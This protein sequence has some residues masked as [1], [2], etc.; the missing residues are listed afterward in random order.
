MPESPYLHQAPSVISLSQLEGPPLASPQQAYHG[1]SETQIARSTSTTLDTFHS[2]PDTM[3]SST[4]HT[5]EGSGA[6]E[7]SF[8]WEHLP[9][10]GIVPAAPDAGHPVV[11]VPSPTHSGRRVSRV[12]RILAFFGY[13][14]DNK[15]RKELVSVIWTLSIDLSQMVAIIVLLAYSTHHRSPV[16]PDLNEWEACGKPLGV[17]NALWIGRLAL[18][19]GLAYWRWS[20]ERTKRAS[21]ESAGSGDAEAGP[22]SHGAPPPGTWQ[23]NPA[24]GRTAQVDPPPPP[25]EP[26]PRVYARL[27]LLG[28]L[29]TLVWFVLAHI[30]EYTSTNTCRFASPHLWWLTFAVLCVMYFMILEVFL[31]AM[32]VFVVGPILFLFWSIVLLC[33]GRH[34][35]QNPHII[36]PE[37]GKLS[38]SIVDDIPLVIY[39]PTPPDEPSK[40]IAV[41]KT[42]Y[43]YPPKPAAPAPMPRRRFRLLSRFRKNRNKGTDKTKGDVQNGEGTDRPLTW[44]DHWEK[45]DY[46]FVRLPGNRAACAICLLDFE[47]PRRLLPLPE[48]E[49][50]EQGKQ[51][52]DV[53][54]PEAPAGDA[55]ESVYQVEPLSPPPPVADESLRLEDAGEGVQ[56]LRLLDCGHVFHQTCVDPWLIDVSGRCPVCQRPVVMKES[57]RSAEEQAERPRRWGRR[58]SNSRTT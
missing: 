28:S 22:Q 6:R 38:K 30:F 26:Y 25:A 53:Q 5:Q 44:E 8:R 15:A 4:P 56:P 24:T 43:T 33:L 34:P 7:A 20:K 39:I 48:A 57:N 49:Q 16:F 52:A 2:A 47:E 12:G 23:W 1:A 54:A 42:A 18:D 11:V 40:P 31:I 13:G 37:I 45:G 50:E 27:S 17:W 55:G 41:P 46:P 36:K 19:I 35:V 21:D 9:P 32:L 3:P 10:L 58:R 29:F 14:R 51:A